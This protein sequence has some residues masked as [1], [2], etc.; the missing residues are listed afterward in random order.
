M[1]IFSC[2]KRV[3]KLAVNYNLIMLFFSF[4]DSFTCCFFTKV[5]ELQ[6]MQ[7]QKL[8]G[9]REVLS[10]VDVFIAWKIWASSVRINVNMLNIKQT[11]KAMTC[12][13]HHLYTVVDLAFSVSIEEGSPLILHF[14]HIGFAPEHLPVSGGWFS[15]LHSVYTELPVLWNTLIFTLCVYEAHTKEPAK[16][17]E[18]IRNDL[19]WAGVSPARDRQMCNFEFLLEVCRQRSYGC[20]QMDEFYFWES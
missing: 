3:R 10:A 11:E 15:T 4:L 18:Q 14:I 17:F 20:I 1:L 6:L 13:S 12:G 2:F 7:L 8:Q 16:E 9:F 19:Y 5:L